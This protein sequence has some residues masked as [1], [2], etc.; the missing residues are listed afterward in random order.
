LALASLE[1]LVHCDR[2]LVPSDL[3]AIEIEVP[4]TVGLEELNQRS[5]PRTWRT[6]PAPTALQR[7][8]N[9]WLDRATACLLRVPSALVPSEGN[10]LINPAHPDVSRLRIVRKTAFRL[11]SRLVKR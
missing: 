7:L 2:D 9:T 6:Y 11:D 10:F 5:L 4:K 8:G 3:I 1:V